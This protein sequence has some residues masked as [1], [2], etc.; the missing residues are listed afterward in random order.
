MTDSEMNGWFALR[1][2]EMG[3]RLRTCRGG[4]FGVAGISW[5]NFSLS[6]SSAGCSK[7][8]LSAMRRWFQWSGEAREH[9]QGHQAQSYPTNSSSIKS[10]TRVRAIITQSSNNPVLIPIMSLNNPGNNDQVRKKT[11]TYN[12]QNPGP[13]I[14]FRQVRSSLEGWM[15]QN[16]QWWSGR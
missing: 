8:T 12:R 11:G 3:A 1:S 2:W 9:Y 14:R 13:K 5:G 6:D 16:Y 4:E 7:A 15:F 10:L